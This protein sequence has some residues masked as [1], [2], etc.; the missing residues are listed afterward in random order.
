MWFLFLLFYLVLLFYFIF[1]PLDALWLQ[2]LT[3]WPYFVMLQESSLAA[4][5]IFFKN[6][7]LFMLWYCFMYWFLMRAFLPFPMHPLGHLGDILARYTW[8]ES[9]IASSG[10]ISGN[11]YATMWTLLPH[12][13]PKISGQLR[14]RNILSVLSTD[15]PNFPSL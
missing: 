15:F 5:F 4:A 3:N 6:M 9:A 12:H 1:L 8:N 13:Y 14:W 10:Y 11:L 2:K 7:Y